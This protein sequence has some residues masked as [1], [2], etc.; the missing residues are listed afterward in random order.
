[1]GE[2][3]GKGLPRWW[4]AAGILAERVRKRIVWRHL[5]RNVLA[6]AN[7]ATYASGTMS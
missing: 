6:V 4:S 5:A 2:V 7:E 1:M 3:G